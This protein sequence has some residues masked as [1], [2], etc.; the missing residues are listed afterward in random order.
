MIY[1]LIILLANSTRTTVD[2]GKTAL[3]VEFNSKAACM[4]A[5]AE[6]TRQQRGGQMTLLCAEKG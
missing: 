4:A 3:S 6:I 1:I 5:A 2:A